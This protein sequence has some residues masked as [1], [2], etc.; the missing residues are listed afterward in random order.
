MLSTLALLSS[1]RRHGNTGLLTD[2]IARGLGAEV[3]DLSALRLAPYDYQYRNRDD[4]FEPLIKRVLAHRQVILAT[5][6][7]WYAVSPAM[8]VFLDRLCDLLEL[9]DL[10]AEGRRLRGMN[11]YV[12]CTSVD[13]APD[14][15]FLGAWRATLGYLG[16]RFA[17]IAHANCREGLTSALLES[18]A[19][20]FIARVREGAP[21]SESG[22]AAG[23]RPS[24]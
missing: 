22:S 6:I 7:Y 12:V 2:R 9:P 14:A 17:G 11:A 4:D 1:S 3:V 15:Q 16:M 21:P 23:A 20:A 8:K 18:T 13:E 10:L 19:G 5:P 24:P